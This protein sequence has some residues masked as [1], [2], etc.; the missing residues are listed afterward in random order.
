MISGLSDDAVSRMSPFATA[1]FGLRFPP[2]R[3]SELA[4]GVASAGLELGVSDLSGWVES[5]LSGGATMVHLQ[6]LANHLTV[7]ETYF[8]RHREVFAALAE[9]IL[10]ERFAMR[11][12]QA[13]SVR[14]WSAACASGEEPYSVAMIVRRSL[15]AV[16]HGGV[17]IF[18]TDLNS[19]VLAR[20]G[21]GEFSEWSFRDTPAWVK[22]SYFTRQPSGRY[23]IAPEIRHMVRFSR[24]NFA[25]AVYPAEFGERGDFDAIL[26]RNVLMYFSPEW[27]ETIVRRLCR[28]LA[29]AGWLIVGPCDLSMTQSQELGL[30]SAGPGIFQ[31]RAAG[32]VFDD[33]APPS[34]HPDVQPLPA[35]WWKPALVSPAQEI[36]TPVADFVAPRSI[37]PAVSSIDSPVLPSESDDAL[38]LAQAHADRGE[39]ARALTACDAAIAGDKLNPFLHYLRACILQEQ[40]RFDEA[41]QSFHRVLYLDPQSIIGNFALGI[42]AERQVRRNEARHHFAIAQRLLE[43]RNRGDAVPGGEGLTV[44]RLRALVETNLAN[45]GSPS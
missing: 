17:A 21:R 35:D 44:G 2:D 40:N 16:A 39:L 14:V 8:L 7:A 27:Q 33:M 19:H 30:R 34:A 15:P 26:C 24:L 9:Q 45:N 36:A 28:A 38:A 6:A 31:Q 4:R 20:A 37:D 18:G 12:A 43:G 13:R 29:P 23:E 3:W 5:V 32:V 1:A 42:L 22:A 10:P 41:A 11:Q 25:D